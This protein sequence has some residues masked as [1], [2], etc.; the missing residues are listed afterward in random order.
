MPDK[1]FVIQEHATA[2]GT[3][4]DL[5]LEEGDAL[6][7]FRLAQMPAAGPGHH[8]RAERIFDHPLRFLAYEGPVQQG[9][10]RVHIVARGTYRHLAPPGK[11]IVV[12]FEGDVLGGDFTL[13][14]IAETQWDFA[15]ISASAET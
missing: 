15:P 1:R 3:H 2:A 10:G 4:W 12:K 13:K 8:V 6:T 14:Q 11:T 9:T 5:M 7:T